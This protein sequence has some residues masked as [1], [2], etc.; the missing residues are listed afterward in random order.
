MLGPKI[1]EPVS[2]FRGP[3]RHRLLPVGPSRSFR[4]LEIPPKSL[5]RP[6]PPQG[7]GPKFFTWLTYPLDGPEY[8]CIC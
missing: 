8:Y 4:I 1:S 7:P 3:S 5:V 2:P 6:G